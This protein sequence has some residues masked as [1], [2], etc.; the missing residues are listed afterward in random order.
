MKAKRPF[1]PQEAEERDA[2]WTERGRVTPEK[3][4]TCGHIWI[5]D[6]DSRKDKTFPETILQ[7]IRL[8]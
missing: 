6:L 1:Q 3:G 7:F 2:P 4:Q 5:Q 8:L